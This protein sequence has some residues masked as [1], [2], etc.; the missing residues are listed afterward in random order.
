MVFSSWLRSS[1]R[2][3][4]HA[5][6][7]ADNLLVAEQLSRLIGRMNVADLRENG[8]SWSE[9]QDSVRAIQLPNDGFVCVVDATNGTVLCHPDLTE[10][11]TLPGEN[12]QMVK[13]GMVKPGMVKPPM[14]KPP[15]NKPPMV[16]PGMK[17]PP[18]DSDDNTQSHGM[19]TDYGGELQIIAAAFLPDLN[20]HV[21]VHQK[22]SGIKR[23]INRILQTA[24]P[25]GLAISL[26]LV[27]CTT[28][29]VIG[30]M[31]NYDYRLATINEGLEDLVQ[32]RTHSLRRT[33][34]SVIFGLAKL[35][36]SRDTDT[37]EHLDRIRL[38]VTIL[39][40]QL[41]KTNPEIDNNYIENLSIA[42]SL[43]DIGKVGIPDQILL[44]P[45]HFSPEEREVMKKHAAIGGECLEAI[46]GHL[47]EDDFLQLARDIAYFHHEKW[48]GSGYPYGVEGKAIPIAARIV[49]LADVYDA[50]R[51][52]RPYKDPMPHEK[53]KYIIQQ[54]R[55]SH[56]EPA[57]VDAFVQCESYFIEVSERYNH[58]DPSKASQPQQVPVS[59]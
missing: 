47:G 57:I 59:C 51:S 48:D 35:A 18:M 42:S 45:G 55:G 1:I 36:E 4:V 27:G 58:I 9:L 38:Y 13:P 56:F 19:I 11:P 26:A 43:H 39:A 8:E 33:R 29:L 12:P 14:N 28:A 50:L 2:E 6:V 3:T 37:G 5:Q 25:F 34:D 16:K 53:A 24:V 15:M 10:S 22:A 49:A 23:N 17:K 46:S 54:G 7:L 44:K 31:R 20:A 30:I 41:S 40:G 32:K 21:N 52:R